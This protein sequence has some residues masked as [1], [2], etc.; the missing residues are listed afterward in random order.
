MNARDD[1]FERQLNYS[2]PSDFEYIP[3][4]ISS[5]LEGDEIYSAPQKQDVTLARASLY[6]HIQVQRR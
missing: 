3:L 2:L 6:L 5:T 4:L 1:T